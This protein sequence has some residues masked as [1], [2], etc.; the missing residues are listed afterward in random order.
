MLRQ[1][2]DQLGSQDPL[3]WLPGS[4]SDLCRERL[5][6]VPELRSASLQGLAEEALVPGNAGSQQMP[7]GLLHFGQIPREGGGQAWQVRLVGGQQ[8]VEDGH[9]GG[10]A[11]HLFFPIVLVNG[12]EELSV[13]VQ[14]LLVPMFVVPQCKFRYPVNPRTLWTAWPQLPT[15]WPAL[16]CKRL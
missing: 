10:D 2:L 14:D 13:N 11:L 4:S 1:G 9:G 3:P 15:S 5:Y 8:V 16:R 6:T 12:G 7:M